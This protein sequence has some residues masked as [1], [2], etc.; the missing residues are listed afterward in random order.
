MNDLGLFATLRSQSE[1]VVPSL[2]LM[3]ARVVAREVNSFDDVVALNAPSV[4]RLLASMEWLTD[5]R[6][7]A[8][9][10]VSEFRA[11]T[12]DKS[13]LNEDRDTVDWLS[14]RFWKHTEAFDPIECLLF[15]THCGHLIDLGWKPTYWKSEGAEVIWR[16][17]EVNAL[18]KICAQCALEVWL[19]RAHRD[20][21]GGWSVAST[22]RSG[23]MRD[24]RT[25]VDSR[26]F[27]NRLIND[28]GSWCSRCL[29]APLFEL[30][31]ASSSEVAESKDAESDD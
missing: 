3:A 6:D 23:V 13:A 8:A 31:F 30:R 18:C 15:R 22:F 14:K 12:D 17:S 20:V 1:R 10:S 5:V 28:P 7:K 25:V 16:Y 27:A 29:I 24:E 19:T 21:Y 11:N 2:T 9:T 26:D 4:C